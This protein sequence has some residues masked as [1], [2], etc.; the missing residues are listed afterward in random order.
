MNPARVAKVLSTFDTGITTASEV[1]NCLL[2]DLV[3]EAQLD[4]SFLESVGRLPD[5]VQRELVRILRRIRDAGFH[6]TPFTLT[7]GA[8]GPEPEDY[9]E[10]LRT[11]YLMV[12]QTDPD[13]RGEPS[14]IVPPAEHRRHA[15]GFPQAAGLEGDDPG[16]F[17]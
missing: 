14:R 9:P 7:A 13:F 10:K 3:N 17:P 8:R 12:A 16:Q 2:H 5:E 11:V 15:S 6:W 1:A 4:T